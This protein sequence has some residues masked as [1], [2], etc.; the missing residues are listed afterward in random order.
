M[1]RLVIAA[2]MMGVSLATTSPAEAKSIWLKCD[3][4]IINLDSQK[5][6]YSL[7]I[8]KNGSQYIENANNRIFYGPATFNPGQINFD[9]RVLDYGD[10]G[11]GIKKL[12]R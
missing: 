10:V 3:V 9:F 5:E 4:L 11:D 2:A 8:E 12:S 1:R 7:E 6:K